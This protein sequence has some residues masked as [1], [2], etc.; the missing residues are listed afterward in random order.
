MRRILNSNGFTLIELIIVIIIVGIVSVVV[1]ELLVQATHAV[2]TE[3][4]AS[5]VSSQARITFDKMVREI[6]M[7]HDLPSV[8]TIFD[9]N[10]I[11]FL[12]LSGTCIEYKFANDMVLRSEGASCVDASAIA[13]DNAESL[14]FTYQTANFTNLADP[15]NDKASIRYVTIDLTAAEAPIE[16]GDK[17]IT[18]NLHNVVYLI[19]STS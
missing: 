11:R 18:S 6:R 19:N 10:R 13:I 9:T 16:G 17:K 8:N 14:T 12:T 3:H 15:N 2:A 1:S 5:N 7:Q 4:A